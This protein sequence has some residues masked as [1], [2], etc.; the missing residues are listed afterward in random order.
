MLAILFVLFSLPE[1]DEWFAAIYQGFKP[2]GRLVNSKFTYKKGESKTSER[3]FATYYGVNAQTFNHWIKNCCP[4]WLRMVYLLSRKQVNKYLEAAIKRYLGKTQ[5]KAKKKAA[6]ATEQF[7][8]LKKSAA[9][10]KLQW[11]IV[12]KLGLLT[13]VA[14]QNL[15]VLPPR[16][17]GAVVGV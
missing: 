1:V 5:P 13:L 16:V 17:V 4:S 10:E 12:E 3:G 11:L 14:Y 2:F 9:Y 7:A 15:R 8:E 6:L